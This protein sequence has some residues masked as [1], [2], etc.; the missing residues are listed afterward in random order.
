MSDASLFKERDTDRQSNR[1][2]DRLTDRFILVINEFLLCFNHLILVFG[3]IRNKVAGWAWMVRGVD[4][5]EE[6]KNLL[7][8]VIDQ[9]DTLKH[10]S[11]H[12]HEDEEFGRQVC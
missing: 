4:V 7:T 12:W 5:I 8:S 10:I 3:Y 6:K 1:H 11:M 2:T 9:S